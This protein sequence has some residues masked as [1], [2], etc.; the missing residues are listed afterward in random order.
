MAVVAKPRQELA[1]RQPQNA[2]QPALVV[3]QPVV[4]H[5]RDEAVM[6]ARTLLLRAMSSSYARSRLR[7]C[8]NATPEVEMSNDASDVERG[9]TDDIQG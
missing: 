2:E 3:R 7:T 1:A 8:R 5:Q 6:G 4:C 9:G